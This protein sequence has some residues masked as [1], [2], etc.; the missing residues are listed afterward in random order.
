MRL[1]ADIRAF[2]RANRVFRIGFVVALG[3]VGCRGVLGIEDSSVAEETT[4]AGSNHDEAETATLDEVEAQAFDESAPDVDGDVE[5][6]VDSEASSCDVLGTSENCGSCGHDCLGG[7]CENGQCRPE[8]LHETATAYMLP[9]LGTDYVFVSSSPGP[10]MYRVERATGQVG[11]TSLAGAG[12]VGLRVHDGFVYFADFDG[13]RILRGAESGSF[14]VSPHID[15]SVVSSF[16]VWEV[17]VAD[18]SIYFPDDCFSSVGDTIWRANL[19][20]SG[21]VPVATGLH[22]INELEADQDDLW[23]ASWE[24]PELYRLPKSS[25]PLDGG[26]ITPTKFGTATNLQCTALELDSAYAYVAVAAM[27]DSAANGI[28]IY[29]VDKSG[30][31]APELVAPNAVNVKHMTLSGTHLYWVERNAGATLKGPS[32]GRIMRLNTTDAN[33]LPELLLGDLPSPIGLVVDGNVIYFTSQGLSPDKPGIYR[34][35]L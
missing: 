22:C 21:V 29:R 23:A 6:D 7:A 10:N 30:A 9:A 5:A 33:P 25:L 1:L 28:G 14:G 4:D 32:L 12:T 13:A 18:D 11:F 2:V 17:L 26:S 20:G 35:V 19:D 15:T 8:L 31:K 24:E 27:D 16:S 34:V 3:F